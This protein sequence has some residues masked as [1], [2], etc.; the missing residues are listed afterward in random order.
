MLG[1]IVLTKTAA[2]KM[3][4]RME[5]MKTQW[6]LDRIPKITGTESVYNVSYL[7]KLL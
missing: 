5:T 6:A 3:R 7:K 1:M 2:V 4:I